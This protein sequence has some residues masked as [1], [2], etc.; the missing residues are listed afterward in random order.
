MGCGDARVLLEALVRKKCCQC[1]G[2]EIEENVVTRARE[3]V[4]A[5]PESFGPERVQI[6]HDDLRTVLSELVQRVSREEDTSNSTNVVPLPEVLS[7]KHPYQDLPM[8][9]VV[10]LHLLPEGIAEIENDLVKLLPHMTIVC[11]SWGL[12]S[13][14]PILEK[15][16][17]DRR[18]KTSATLFLYTKECF[19]RIKGFEYMLSVYQYGH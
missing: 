4:G 10:F 14:R 15:D 18:S 17:Y 12:K 3:L 19:E 2:V 5:I 8:P 16:F 1:V 11:C 13:I 6:I 7:E 9:T